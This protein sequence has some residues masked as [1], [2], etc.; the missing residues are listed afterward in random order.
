[1]NLSF[2]LTEALSGL[3]KSSLHTFAAVVA[4]TLA[5]L[6]L[7]FFNY[8]ILNLKEATD[9]LLEGLEIQAFIALNVPEEKHESIKEEIQALDDRWKVT[10]ISR[11]EAAAEFAAEFDP[12]LF[13]VL[14][15]NPLPASFKI[16]LPAA[17][18]DPVYL[19]AVTEN[20]LAINGI[21]DVIYDRDLLEMLSAAKKKA[22]I[23]GAIIA[24]FIVLVSVGVTVNA[25]RLKL[26]A[27]Q[28]AFRLMQLLG[29]TSKTIRAIVW[30]QGAILGFAGGLLGTWLTGVTAWLVRLQLP[31]DLAITTP[32]L[33][34]FILIGMLLTTL[35]SFIAIRR[36]LL[37]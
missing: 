1:M 34:V 5:V 6:F 18:M 19:E 37:F 9:D 15:E 12:E 28:D 25:L 10:Y 33:P 20:I 35:C 11:A 24:L 22:A 8:T 4:V 7:G 2:I 32:F 13:D 26:H 30:V 27:Q 14:D 16:Q 29:A 3:R 23:G 36:F 17:A 21:D 31:Q